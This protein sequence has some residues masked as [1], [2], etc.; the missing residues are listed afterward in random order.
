MGL[1]VA[2]LSRGVEILRLDS[3]TTTVMEHRFHDGRRVQYLRSAAGTIGA[4]DIPE[5]LKH[6]PIVLLGPVI[7]EVE[8]A[9][10]ASFSGALVGATAQGWLRRA[11]PDGRLHDGNVA[12]LDVRTLAGQITVLTL[13]EDDLAGAGIPSAWLEAFP[14]VIVTRGRDGLEC[15]QSGHC[16]RLPAFPVVERD[17]TGAGDA[18]AAAFL[19]DYA[20]TRNAAKAAR[21][22]AAVA[23]FIVEAAGIGGAPDREQV[24]ARLRDHPEVQPAPCP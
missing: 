10:A 5:A 24:E 22:G 4:G 6:A 9:V 23:S 8:A 15:Y 11:T 14:I 18:F 20:E 21:F 2:G 12:G 1:G 7:G 13:S 17:A 19:I 3:P 16:W